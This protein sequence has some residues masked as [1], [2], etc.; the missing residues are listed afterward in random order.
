M[1]DKDKE[2]TK[3]LEL[4]IN[5]P[6]SIDGK[7]GTISMQKLKNIAKEMAENWNVPTC[8]ISFLSNSL[9]Q[10]QTGRVLP[11]RDYKKEINLI[12][13]ARIQYSE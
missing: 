5:Q 7:H 9:D 6:V 10:Q 1:K 13:E 3:T 4:N 8:I 2:L 12:Y 11:W